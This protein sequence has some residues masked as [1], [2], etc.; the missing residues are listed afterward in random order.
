MSSRKPGYL[1]GVILLALVMSAPQLLISFQLGMQA[2]QFGGWPPSP[3]PRIGGSMFYGSALSQTTFWRDQFLS[4]GF[5]KQRPEG[6]FD[7]K[8][9][10]IDP[11]S[12]ESN[13]TDLSLSGRNYFQTMSFGDRVWFIGNTESYELVDGAFRPT[14]F[15]APRSWPGEGQRFLLNGEPAYVEGANNGFTVSTLKVGTWGNTVDVVVPA[16][17]GDWTF[18]FKRGAL[19]TCL[20]HGDRIHVFLH[21]EG[22]LLH[23]EGLELQPSVASFDPLTGQFM[24]GAGS[25]DHPVSALRAANSDGKST[26][27][28]LV[29]ESASESRDVRFTHQNLFGMLVGDQPAALIIDDKQSGHPMGH[30][31]RFDGVKWSEFATQA[32]PFGTNQFRVVACR[33]GQK[34]YLVASTST[35]AA[36]VYAVEASGIR[37]TNGASKQ[38]NPAMQRLIGYPIFPAV[39]LV[40]GI[41][42]GLGTWCLMWW[43]TKPDYGFG[44]QTVKLASLG[45]RGLARL[46]DLALIVFSTAGLGW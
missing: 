37:A 18:D 12:G 44:V 11:E 41:I 5:G 32:F 16:R 13:A 31:H 15:A 14:Q 1:I 42:L 3:I 22:R 20:N 33:D 29:R 43:Y 45:R 28:T 40:L 4:V 38:S 7:W 2:Y 35:G 46:I 6:G 27:W 19:M 21:T 24:G 23:R 36:H 26:G 9:S 25:A 39:M 17:H 30:L 34:S 10:T 8:V